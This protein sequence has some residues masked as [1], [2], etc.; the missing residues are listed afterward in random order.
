[1]TERPQHPLEVP[2]EPTVP[3]IPLQRVVEADEPTLFGLPAEVGEPAETTDDVAPVRLVSVRR[4]DP[5]AGVL[6]V[7]AGI[8]AAASLWLP[9]RRGE[10]V[11]GLSLVRQGLQVAGSDVRALGPGGLWQPLAIVLGGVVLFL[12]GV[13]MFGPAR[14]HRI[15]GLLALLVASGAGAAVVLR[16]AH[17]GWHVARS[18]LGLWCAVAVAGLGLLGAL[19]AMLTVPRITTR[20]RRE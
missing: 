16:V 12:L 1:M 8:A 13:L 14:T 2:P 19:K 11:T 15:S 17:A 7:L 18:D 9:W 6:L 3:G 20:R 4:A 10:D 5:L